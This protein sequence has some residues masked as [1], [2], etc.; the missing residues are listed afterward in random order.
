MGFMQI[1]FKDAD[2]NLN[3]SALYWTA[4]IHGVFVASALV[5]S[6]MEYINYKAK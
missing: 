2:A 6:M 3:I 5:L 4:V 1:D